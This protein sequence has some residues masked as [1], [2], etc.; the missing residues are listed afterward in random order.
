MGQADSKDAGKVE[1]IPSAYGLLEPINNNQR[2]TVIIAVDQSKLSEAAFEYY[3]KY[4][5]KPQYQV[6][7][8]HCLEVPSA[9]PTMPDTREYFEK[10]MGNLEAEGKSVLQKYEDKMKQHDIAGSVSA[11]YHNKAGQYIVDES[12]QHRAATIVMATRGHG[13]IRRT[14]LGSVSQFVIHH[15][16]V[17]VTLVPREWMQT[18]V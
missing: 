3:V 6:R 4:L 2:D 16:Q 10:Y 12:E 15:S 17:P 14:I 5:H 13:V 9:A 11:N 1:P 7:V 18:V 8:V